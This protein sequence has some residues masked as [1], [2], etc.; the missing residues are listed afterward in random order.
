MTYGIDLE[1]MGDRPEAKGRTY[2]IPDLV[3]VFVPKFDDPAA[4]RADQVVVVG[5][6]GRKLIMGAFPLESVFG[7]NAALGEQFQGRVYGRPGH[8]VTRRVH[9]HVELISRKMVVQL[10]YT[11]QY[12]GPLLGVPVLLFPEVICEVCF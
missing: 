2:G 6:A 5:H 4:L 8:A 3:D 12:P 1:R 11:I 9:V 10:G 7:K